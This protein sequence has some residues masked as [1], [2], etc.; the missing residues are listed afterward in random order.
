M[1]WRLNRV[2]FPVYNL[3]RGMR[4]AIWVQGCSIGCKGCI[5]PELCDVAA[6]REIDVLSFVDGLQKIAGAFNGITITG[7]EPFD[8]YEALISFST[9][10]KLKSKTEIIVFSGY[11]LAELISMHPDRLFTKCIDYLIDG[12]YIE[13]LHENKNQRGSV[14]QKMYSFEP[15]GKKASEKIS[16]EINIVEV[17]F[18]EAAKRWSLK[19]DEE[20]RVFMT[21]IPRSDDF[22][23]IKEQLKQ[24]GIKI[25]L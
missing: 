20:H 6:G 1:R 8:Q 3:G 2:I 13:N 4:L 19:V 16:R 22:D 9:F 15:A 25:E 18:P 12:P 21:G 14:N 17:D 7:G 11:T 24:S 5:N 23:T 10:L